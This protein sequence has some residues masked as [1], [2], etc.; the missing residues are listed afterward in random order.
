MAL[1]AGLCYSSGQLCAV[2]FVPDD[3]M[4]PTVERDPF[5]RIFDESGERL[6]GTCGERLSPQLDEQSRSAL[7]VEEEQA[8]RALGVEFSPSLIRNYVSGCGH[9]VLSILTN[10]TRA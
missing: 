2:S 6:C 10:G 7:T 4:L 9:A 3:G 5:G 8:A 1:K